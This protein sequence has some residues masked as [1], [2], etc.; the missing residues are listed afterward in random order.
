MEKPELK[1]G[2]RAFGGD[3]EGYHA[4]RPDYPAR[5]FELLAGRRAIR[6]GARAFEIGP[7]TGKAT[8]P[9]LALGLGSITAVE[10]D[11]RLAAWLRAALPDPRLTV[12]EATFEAA[13]AA[14][15]P[16]RG[17]DLGYAATS[18]HW[19]DAA[20]AL[21]KAARLLRPGG[22]WA[23]WWNIYMDPSRPDPF[24][25]AV[26]P[27]LQALRAEAPSF[28]SD[29]PDALPRGLAQALRTA[30]RLAELEAAGFVGAAVETLHW[31]ARFDTAG[32]RALYGS[33]SV[34]RDV[35]PERAEACLDRIAEIAEARFGGTVERACTTVLYTARAPG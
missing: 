2:R 5:L 28:R 23:M 4:A 10:P 14:C 7:G 15:L 20:P 29:P 9:M 21:A 26:A 27:L 12:L 16:E 22:S 1:L 33:F 30:E 32:M 24:R 11:A 6:A 8:G 34:M 25:D 35:A 3:P 19:L 13:D 17:F 18:F 31:Q